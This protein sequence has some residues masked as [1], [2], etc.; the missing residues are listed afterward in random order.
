MVWIL[1]FPLPPSV[2]SYLMPVAGKIKKNKL[3]KNSY[4]Q[5]MLVKTQAHRDYESECILWSLQI[6]ERLDKIKERIFFAMKAAENDQVPFALKV[7]LYFCLEHSRL[8]TKN[9][10]VQRIDR[11]NRIKPA[12]D[13]L[14]HILGIDDKY[15]FAGNAEKVTAQ[16]KDEECV[17]IR[18]SITRPRTKTQILELASSENLA[19][20]QSP[21]KKA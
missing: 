10:K 4:R 12:T 6:K 7:D 21:Q 9:N 2:N 13:Q 14:H 3:T 16:S 15:I 18:I 5:G 19:H 20:S 8:I 11:D 1:D 17:I